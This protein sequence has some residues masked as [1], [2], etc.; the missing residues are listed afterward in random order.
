MSGIAVHVEEG[1]RARRAGRGRTG[2]GGK[3]GW[4]EGRLEGRGRG[5]RSESF[6]L[7]LL[8]SSSYVHHVLSFL[9]FHGAV[10]H[11]LI[12]SLIVVLIISSRSRFVWPSVSHHVS[13][14]AS[15]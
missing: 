6:V 1:R 7:S 4:G 3:E 12:L 15:S 2:G 8:H 11:L 13:R 9:F 10:H 14:A 5:E